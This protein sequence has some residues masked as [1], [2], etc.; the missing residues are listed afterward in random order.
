MSQSFTQTFCSKNGLIWIEMFW[1][2]GIILILFK[3]SNFFFD[4]LFKK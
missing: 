2:C 4:S 3:I 1:I